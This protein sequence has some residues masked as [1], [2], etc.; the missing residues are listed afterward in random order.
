MEGLIRGKNYRNRGMMR[1]VS[2]YDGF[3]F[4]C[5]KKTIGCIAGRY[6]QELENSRSRRYGTKIDL[7]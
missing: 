3:L 4:D 6:L 5:E 2:D 1:K 7:L